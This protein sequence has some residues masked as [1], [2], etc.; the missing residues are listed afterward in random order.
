M[1]N[2]RAGSSWLRRRGRNVS[3]PMAVPRR[4]VSS[5]RC[6][7]WIGNCPTSPVA[8]TVIF[9]A[10]TV[11]STNPKTLTIS[12]FIS[13]I[14][15]LYNRYKEHLLVLLL[16]T[17]TYRLSDMFLGPMAMPFYQDMGFSEGDYPEAEKYY[18]RRIGPLREASRQ[19]N[20]RRSR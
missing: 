10:V 9:L 16:L 8:P 13:P 15:D 14:T 5:T 2:N 12:A 3:Q 4:F 1:F 19:T 6:H 20:R 17:F 18:Q 7:W 11:P